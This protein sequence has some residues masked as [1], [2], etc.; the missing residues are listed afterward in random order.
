MVVREVFMCACIVAAGFFCVFQN[1]IEPS[2]LVSVKVPCVVEAEKIF[3][4]GGYETKNGWLLNEDGE[5]LYFMIDTLNST[6]CEY[7]FE[8]KARACGN[9]V[10][11]E[12][13]IEGISFSKIEVEPSY[14]YLSYRDRVNIKNG[15]HRFEANLFSG[16]E[17]GDLEIDSIGVWSIYQ[18]ETIASGQGLECLNDENAENGSY[19][20]LTEDGDFFEKQIYSPREC[21][22]TFKI[23]GKEV[24]NGTEHSQAMLYVDGFEFGTINV[25]SESWTFYTLNIILSEGEH[26]V[27]VRYTK[28]VLGR[29]LHIDEFLFGSS[30]GEFVDIES[31]E[32]L[33]P[34]LFEAEALPH[35]GGIADVGS[36]VLKYDNDMV[37]FHGRNELSSYYEFEVDAFSYGDTKISLELDGAVL[38][39][40][41]L[42]GTSTLRH[43]AK[44]DA[45]LHTILVRFSSGG[46]LGDVSIDKIIVSYAIQG[47][48][49]NLSGDFS[50]VVKDITAECGLAAILSKKGDGAHA[51]LFFPESGSYNLSIRAKED[52]SG[53]EH[54][55]GCVLIDGLERGTFDVS[56]NWRWYSIQIDKI[57]EG[58]HNISF[59][60]LNDHYNNSAKTDRNLKIDLFKLSP[61]KGTTKEEFVIAPCKIEGESLQNVTIYGKE[62]KLLSK[63]WVYVKFP[64]SCNY[65]VEFVAR[66]EFP[67]SVR[68]TLEDSSIDIKIENTTNEIYDLRFYV[69][70]GTKYLIFEVIEGLGIFIDWVKIS[71][72]IECENFSYKV[73]EVW[74]IGDGNAS[75]GKAVRLSKGDGNYLSTNIYLPKIDF[76]DLCIKAKEDFDTE[77]SILEISLG[78]YTRQFRIMSSFYEW[79][80]LRVF[81]SVIGYERLT[82]RML[83]EHEGS[84]AYIDLVEI[85]YERQAEG[86]SK[87]IC[88]LT[89]TCKIECENAINN[90]DLRRDSQG[91]VLENGFCIWDNGSIWNWIYV[92]QDAYYNFSFFMKGIFYKG[93]PR[94]YFILDDRIVTEFELIQ[95]WRF[96]NGS[97]YIEKGPRKFE[98]RYWN[99]LW[100]GSP[101]KDRSPIIDFMHF[102]FGDFSYTLSG[103]VTNQSGY[104]LY[105]ELR[106]DGRITNTDENGTYSIPCL[107]L[108]SYQASASALGYFTF[109]TEVVL[110]SNHTQ[111]FTLYPE[112]FYLSGL[113]RNEQT[114]E[115]ISDVKISI[116]SFQNSFLL[117]TNILGEYSVFLLKGNYTIHASKEGFADFYSS[118]SINSNTSFNFS[119]TPVY[120][121]SGQVIDSS[122]TL[123]IPNANISFTNSSIITY[124]A[125]TNSQGEYH[126][127]L[128]Y[129][130]YKVTVT[131]DSYI[132]ININISICSNLTYDFVLN[133]VGTL[134]QTFHGD[135]E[136]NFSVSEGIIN[137]YYGANER[138]RWDYFTYDST[139]QTHHCEAG[140]QYIRIWTS[141][142]NGG[143]GMN[144]PTD[145]WHPKDA[146]PLR[147]SGS[148]YYWDWTQLD[149]YIEAVQNASTQPILAITYA[150]YFMNYTYKKTG[151]NYIPDDFNWFGDYCANIVAHYR[152]L[153]KNI[154]YWQIWNEPF[155]WGTWKKVSKG[156]I[157]IQMYKI[158]EQKMHAVNSSIKI[159]GP[160][161]AEQDY[162]FIEDML[163]DSSLNFQLCSW[164]TYATGKFWTNPP[165]PRDDSYVMAR[166]QAYE[167]YAKNVRSW[168]SK[169]RPGKDI[170][171]ILGEYNINSST[172]WNNSPNVDPRQHTLFGAPWTASAL[173]HII[174]GR[175]DVELFFLGTGNPLSWGAI[176]FGFGLWVHASNILV[177]SFYAK[178][179]FST[180]F[181]QGST[182]VNST[183]I[184]ASKIPNLEV[185]AVKKDTSYNIILVQKENITRSF[186]LALNGVS[187]HVINAHTIDV[188]SMQGRHYSIPPDNILNITLYGLGVS[189]LEIKVQ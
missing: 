177:P 47:E 12:L 142:D 127:Y 84:A 56:R 175:I 22:Y 151:P 39:S 82:F 106:V 176:S 105:A 132:P 162:S 134:N 7:E 128:K 79:Y 44:L 120:L 185:F 172:T 80:Y 36:W 183:I 135:V 104:P 96:Y 146:T 16:G 42:N 77:H 101:S 189:V 75:G 152:D 125:L 180:Y 184:N 181:K 14:D 164:H 188:N 85:W 45:G 87:P 171:L 37:Y 108:G 52:V 94:V 113:V 148:Y 93:A 131:S 157:Y 159:G 9:P 147:W 26:V 165:E 27:R 49:C 150:P 62:G 48:S 55:K 116:S 70:K 179:Y 15:I 122:T 95:S 118:L 109:Y 169:Y 74:S 19:L 133:K 174:K 24:Q 73:G 33:L 137:T 25:S 88:E 90:T 114:N 145:E 110:T 43:R 66:C 160:S 140:N 60:F 67:T 76:Y 173:I 161:L 8:V 40:W 153:G 38:M 187:P 112:G 23:R 46:A 41:K 117:N 34:G 99:D 59:L 81:S 91:G 65:L 21:E 139:D 30:S 167:D 155:I 168:I 1:E 92:P 115:F 78:N 103:K 18:A 13:K 6:T 129:G 98:L 126:L 144:P 158:V 97:V 53:S 10:S 141:L 71:Q 178:Q 130:I 186:T 136:I 102:E 64:E 119:L 17:S 3:S 58:Y 54:A 163:K 89:N 28:D 31:E 170:K 149:D 68:L 111:N 5:F 107:K 182:I 83:S 123:G 50:Y 35:V 32:Y 72:S 2:V 69:K 63:S 20:R 138:D 86:Y 4:K 29:E 121:V 51:R 100:E 166:T 156:D 57:H 143:Y 154:Q 11:M 61:K 124:Y